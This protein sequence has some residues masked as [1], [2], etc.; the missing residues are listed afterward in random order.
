[1]GTDKTTFGDRTF[2]ATEEKCRVITEAVL[3]HVKRGKG[4]RVLD[5][6]CGCGD[7][8]FSLAARLP[9]ADYLGVDISGPNIENA[10][11]KAAAIDMSGRI[12]FALSNYMD[13]VTQPF[14]VIISDSVLQN[15]DAS[16][17]A[18]FGKIAVDLA[19]D[20]ILIITMPYSCF[21]NSLLWSVRRLLRT[22]RSGFTDRL[23]FA[24]A[25]NI[26]GNNYSE[27]LLLERVNYM[28]LLPHRFFCDTTD[29]LLVSALRANK[30]CEINVEH[31]SIGQPKHKLCIYRKSSR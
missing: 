28:Y 13:F 20:G 17:D 26:H 29:R 11:K 1:M 2:H 31:T 9:E 21:Y 14:D 10:Q 6:G 18:L 27:E 16:S 3:R 22:L 12:S 19:P 5:I 23:I 15:I 30:I 24:I 8:I 4:L 25:K 7:Q